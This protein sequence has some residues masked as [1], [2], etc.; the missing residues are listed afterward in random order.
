M[1]NALGYS[2]VLLFVAF[3]REL[4][5]MGTVFGVT[6]LKTTADGGWY[7][8]NGF[9]TLAPAAALLI[10]CFIWMLRSWKP[11]QIEEEWSVGALSELGG[12]SRI[13]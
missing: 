3:F 12:E 13:R 6:V 2:V 4:L 5:G 11:E 8:V 7:P 9:M 1:G 10:G